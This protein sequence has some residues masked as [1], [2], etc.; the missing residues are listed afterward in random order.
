VWIALRANMRAVL[1]EVTLADL[2]ENRLPAAV[3]ALSSRPE[4]WVTRAGARRTA[5][6]T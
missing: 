4:S 3:A 5:A 1:E 2:V 6:W